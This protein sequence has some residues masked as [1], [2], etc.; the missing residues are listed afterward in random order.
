M[1]G[2]KQFLNRKF[3]YIYGTCHGVLKSKIVQFTFLGVSDLI[4]DFFAKIV[5]LVRAYLVLI[6]ETSQI[7]LKS[8][9][10]LIRPEFI[11]YPFGQLRVGVVLLITFI[12]QKNACV[13]IFMANTATNNLVNF[14]DSSHFVPVLTRDRTLLVPTVVAGNELILE[15][16]LLIPGH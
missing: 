16:L 11:S 4:F 5:S 12:N 3:T 7:L 1:K 2:P 15:R 14:S 6:E 9:V 13:V 10:P 8:F